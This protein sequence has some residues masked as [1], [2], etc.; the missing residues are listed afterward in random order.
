[1]L[2]LEYIKSNIVFPLPGLG[3]RNIKSSL[4]IIVCFFAWQIITLFLPTL[5]MHPLYSYI[6]IVLI[7][8]DTIDKSLKYGR[9]RI[10]GTIIG[11]IVALVIISVY[12]QI[13]KYLYSEIAK[14]FVEIVI[15]VLGASISLYV[16]YI[17]MF[18]TRLELTTL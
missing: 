9:I 6:S 2:V 10:K 11:L 3:K 15:N 8:R 16:A 13:Q 12:M 18:P 7:M 4:S 14:A 5:D 17:C 1:M